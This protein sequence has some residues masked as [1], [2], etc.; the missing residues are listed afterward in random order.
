MVYN[1]EELIFAIKASPLCMVLF[2]LL[3]AV[4][5]A[6]Q[7]AVTALATANFVATAAFIL[8]S[9]SPFQDI[10]PALALVLLTLGIVNIIGSGAGLAASKVRVN[11]QRSLKPAMVKALASL[12][13]YGIRG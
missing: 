12:V 7:T 1:R 8:Q 10:Y 13:I 4:Q 3:P 9:A 5:S 6:V 2:V 11:L